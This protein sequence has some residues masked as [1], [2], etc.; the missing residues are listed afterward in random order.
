MKKNSDK[1]HSSI[2]MFPH[3]FGCF[4]PSVTHLASEKSILPNFS[5]LRGVAILD[6]D[7]HSQADSTTTM[8]NNMSTN[9]VFFISLRKIL[10][11]AM[12]PCRQ[13]C[14]PPQCR[15]DAW[16]GLRDADRTEI[17][18]CVHSMDPPKTQISQ[19]ASPIDNSQITPNFLKGKLSL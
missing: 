16:R 8:C 17:R 10:S 12:S 18:M 13:P 3:R 7:S 19:G 2:G 6:C 14:R 9:L 1:S 15:L 11:D 4:L 5:M